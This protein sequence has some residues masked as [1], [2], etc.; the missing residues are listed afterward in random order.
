MDDSGKEKKPCSFFK[1]SGRRAAVRKRKHS[2]SDEG[3]PWVYGWGFPETLA[4]SPSTRSAV[5]LYIKKSQKE[6]S[7]LRPF[8]PLC[9]ILLQM[10]VMMSQW[11]WGGRERKKE[12]HSSKRQ[13][14]RRQTKPKVKHTYLCERD[15]S[16]GSKRKREIVVVSIHLFLA[17]FQHFQL[18][19]TFSFHSSEKENKAIDL[20]HHACNNLQS[21]LLGNTPTTYVTIIVTWIF[22]R[23]NSISLKGE[24]CS[25]WGMVDVTPSNPL[26]CPLPRPLSPPPLCVTFK[27]KC[28]V[29]KQ[30][31]TN[32]S[33]YWML[34]SIHELEA[35]WSMAE[36]MYSWPWTAFNAYI[37]SSMLKVICTGVDFGYGTE[38]RQCIRSKHL[39]LHSLMKQ[40]SNIHCSCPIPL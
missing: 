20:W 13:A 32:V 2:S 35:M 17:S 12:E 3:K 8:G 21:W 23:W 19:T 24:Y 10:T 37:G 40:D 25:V 22:S 30:H 9:P 39:T 14:H 1:R 34:F 16:N 6:P 31:L 33:T 36:G 7:I 4:F 5:A 27:F 11:W 38:T 18:F 26:P 29:A 15:S 28:L